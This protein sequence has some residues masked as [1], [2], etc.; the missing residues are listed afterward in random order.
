VF[1][2]LNCRS[3]DR[4][5]F[6]INFFS[7]KLLFVSVIAAV[8]AYLAVLQIGFMQNIF[9]TVPLSIEQW[10]WIILVGLLVVIGGEIDKGINKWRKNNLG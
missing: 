9:S 3:L 2:V 5:I 6:R 8:S 4:S 7:N 1:H 10:F